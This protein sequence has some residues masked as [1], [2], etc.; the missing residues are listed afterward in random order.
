[1]VPI[2]S[3]GVSMYVRGKKV[4]RWKERKQLLKRVW[5]ERCRRVEEKR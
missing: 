1:M 4:L 5:R 2:Q 3:V